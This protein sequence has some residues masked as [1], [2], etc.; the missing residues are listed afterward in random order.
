MRQNLPL[1]VGLL[2]GFCLG[3]RAQTTQPNLGAKPPADAAGAIVLFDGE[4]VSHW[5]SAKGGDPTWT[6]TD[7]ALEVNPKTGDIVSKEKFEDCTLHLEFRTPVPAEGDKGQHRGNSGVY[8]QG[9]YEI[10]ILESYGLPGSSGDCASVYSIRAPD[11]NVALPP[12]E[13]QSYDMIF[14]APRYDQD[15]KKTES[16]RLTLIWNGVK[17]HDNVEIP[18]PTRDH[19]APE[20][21]GPGPIVLQDHGFKVQFRNIWI[22]P[23]SEKTAE[24]TGEGADR[25]ELQ[26]LL[27]ASSSASPPFAPRMRSRCSTAKT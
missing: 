12:M 14:R 27:C 10:Q 7:G 15:G 22:V 16:A 6:V 8:L 1:A 23:S 13:W 11:K 9:R 18:S 19:K 4:D 17:V 26:L 25:D 21:P 3:V 2:L 20:P 5:Q 24:K